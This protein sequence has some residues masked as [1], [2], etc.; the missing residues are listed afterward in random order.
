MGPSA[1]A[2]V[3]MGQ[4][5]ELQCKENRDRPLAAGSPMLCC[6][7]LFPSFL[8]LCALQL[9]WMPSASGASNRRCDAAPCLPSAAC[10]R[11]PP[12]PCAT[13]ISRLATLTSC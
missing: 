7:G 13:R 10:A 8:A 1:E 5:D 3:R 6:R 11:V 9:L 12:S 4:V 2:P